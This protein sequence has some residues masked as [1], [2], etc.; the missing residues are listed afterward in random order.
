MIHER[1]AIARQLLIC[2][3][4]IYQTRHG[5][6]SLINCHT[7]RLSDRFPTQPMSFVICGQL[8]DRYSNEQNAIDD[9]SP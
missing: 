9:H 3:K 1:D 7:T 2:E 5:N 4:L 6:V 8:T